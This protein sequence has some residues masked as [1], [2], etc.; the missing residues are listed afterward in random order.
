MTQPDEDDVLPNGEIPDRIAR[1]HPE[2]QDHPRL[3]ALLDGLEQ[4]RD[5]D[6]LRTCLTDLLALLG[7]HF[8]K[9]EAEG[10][11]FDTI[12]DAAPHFT[13]QV[14]T[15]IAQHATLLG[16]ARA[17]LHRIASADSPVDA[18]SMELVRELCAACRTHEAAEMELLVEALYRDLGSHG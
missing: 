6:R 5:K 13:H 16:S 14:N 7:P 17:I 4:E 11:M 1:A 3:E 9:E 2:T 18:T 15:L 12:R 10:A 8:E